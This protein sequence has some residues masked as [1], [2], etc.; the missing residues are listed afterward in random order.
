MDKVK[1][2]YTPR[3]AASLLRQCKQENITYEMAL[4]AM[5]SWKDLIHLVPLKF[6]TE[7]L[8]LLALKR[9]WNLDFVFQHI[10]TEIINAEFILK[11]VKLNGTIL[12]LVPSEIITEEIAFAAIK[13]N[14]IAIKYVP[15][16]LITKAFCEQIITFDKTCL[17]YIPKEFRTKDFLL[18]AV[19]IYPFSIKFIKNDELYYDICKGAVSRNWQ[20]L[21]LIPEKFKTDEIC[22][23]AIRA[24]HK[25]I[26][27]VSDNFKTPELFL[28]TVKKNPEYIAG[29]PKD[30]LTEEFCIQCVELNWECIKY[31]PDDFK[32]QKLCDIGVNKNA[33]AIAF[34]PQ[35]FLS[36]EMCLKA[37]ESDINVLRILPKECKT[38]SICDYAINQSI[39]NIRYIP[40]RFRTME[41]Y[42][43]ILSGLNFSTDFKDWLL[44]DEYSISEQYLIANNLLSKKDLIL[45]DSFKY[46]EFKRIA[47][48]F[49]AD[50]ISN[51]Q[52]A[53]IER[54]L[55]LRVVIESEYD[56][57]QQ[58]FIV[59]ELFCK[60]K[61]RRE[62][63]HF[64]DYYHYLNGNLAGANL[65]EYPLTDTERKKYNLDGAILSST[66]LI[67]QGAYYDDSF[68]AN[69]ISSYLEEVN[70]LPVLV[71]ETVPACAI[72]HADFLSDKLNPNERKVYYISDLHLNHRLIKAFPT[73]ATYDEV[74]HFIKRIIRKMLSTYQIDS[75]DFLLIG[76]D[77][78]F[79]FE[80][81][82]IFYSELAQLWPPNRIIVILGNHELW[83]F[84]RFGEKKENLYLREIIENYSNLFS[85]LNII[86]LHNDLLIRQ[87]NKKG[88]SYFCKLGYDKLLSLSIDDLRK[89]GLNSNIFIL[90]SL[91]F[92]GYNADFN[93][94]KGIYRQTITMIEDDLN[95]TKQFETIYQKLEKAF[96][97]DKVIVFTHTPKDDWA[98]SKSYNPNWIYVNGHTHKNYY[99]ENEDRTIYADNQIGYSS[100]NYDLKYFKVSKDYNIF[101]DYP[102]GIHIIT[103]A[104]YLE[105][106]YGLGIRLSFGRECSEIIMLKRNGYYLFLVQSSDKLRLYLLNG[107]VLNK[108]KNTDIK[109]YFDNM[110]KYGEAI[111]L[112]I[113]S[114]N[115]A[116]KIISEKVKLLGGD[117]TVHGCIVDIDFFNHIFES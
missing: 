52:C 63:E 73:C 58:L 66:L 95:Y 4:T 25:A 48:L 53:I 34:V 17:Q 47:K 22:D 114:Y 23:I 93:A 15:N 105:F 50:T 104:Q 26:K 107:G 55:N 112:N 98:E 77:V 36:E 69:N 92:S 28:K 29:C 117:G 103:K 13:N 79:S 10:P 72:S 78:S 6:R 19:E 99:E 33:N 111:K 61:V 37:V 88:Y 59:Y 42:L 97:N 1:G 12:N 94:T 80:I 40:E 8:C 67:K 108:L 100:M 113:K 2:K 11:A 70:F 65:I 64:A 71:N 16:H 75:D 35:H 41:L 82:K 31:I 83:N 110:T 115:T 89:I 45:H 43:S 46:S 91:G 86:F 18:K 54:K 7:E 76:G 44:C 32:T 87:Y 74:R 14:T 109:Y 57:E 102:D 60:K 116:L 51:A 96:P 5:E 9:T 62:F 101:K 81:S 84:N 38:Q 21:R 68:Y 106:N 24:N 20:V 27:Y 30:L 85:N 56:Q 90:G 49:P 39:D 3:Q